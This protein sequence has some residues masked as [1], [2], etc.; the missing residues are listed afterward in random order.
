MTV[1]RTNKD[2][3]STLSRLVAR[4]HNL[5]DDLLTLLRF[6][7]SLLRLPSVYSYLLWKR[8][9]YSYGHTKYS[10]LYTR[11][12]YSLF[13]K[14]T[15]ILLMFFFGNKRKETKKNNNCIVTISGEHTI[16]SRNCNHLA[17]DLS[18]S[19]GINVFGLVQLKPWTWRTLYL[20]EV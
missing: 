14:K 20:D 17:A 6:V 11:T 10:P 16:H 15:F 9:V 12:K 7:C 4:N 8:T 1:N 2:H 19:Q 13:S 18:P 3:D 5:L